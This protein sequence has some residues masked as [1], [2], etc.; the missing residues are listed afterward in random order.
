VKIFSYKEIKA[1]AIILR[2]S[3]AEAVLDLFSMGSF[4]TGRW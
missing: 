2:R 4:L 1:A 3:L